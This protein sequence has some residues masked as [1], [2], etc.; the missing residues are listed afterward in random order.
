[1]DEQNPPPP[2]EGTTLKF[3]KRGWMYFKDKTPE[4]IELNKQHMKEMR[5]QRKVKKDEGK[6]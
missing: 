5:E 2:K 1:M 6:V 3:T 4:Q